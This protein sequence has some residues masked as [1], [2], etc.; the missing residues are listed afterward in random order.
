MARAPHHFG[1]LQRVGG[2]PVR[3]ELEEIMQ[4]LVQLFNTRRGYGSFLPDFGLS[5]SD[6]MW[7][8]RPMVALAAHVREQIARF[9][10]RLKNAAVEAAPSEDH[11]CPCFWIHGRVGDSVVRLLLS[12]HTIYCHA[13]VKED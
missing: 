7:S 5:I 3:D 8:A 6:I 12:M 13:E 2:Q 4:H 9:E 11:L 10:P 1:L